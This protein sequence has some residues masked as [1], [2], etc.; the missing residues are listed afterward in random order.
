[1]ENFLDKI[2]KNIKKI[3]IITVLN[4]G[5]FETVDAMITNELII[6]PYAQIT[7]LESDK[8]IVGLDIEVPIPNESKRFFRIEADSRPDLVEFI[9]DLTKCGFGQFKSEDLT[10]EE[11]DCL[12]EHGFLVDKNAAP[13]KPLFHYFLDEIEVEND[14]EPQLL[15]NLTVNPSFRFEPFDLTKVSHLIKDNNF[16]PDFPIAWVKLP[17]TEIEVG[18]WLRNEFIE[19]AQK[20]VAG[21][22][23]AFHIEENVLSKFIRAGILINADLRRKKET[24][25]KRRLEAAR[26]MFQ[27]EK[28]VV[29]EEILPSYYM[30][31]MK[32]FFREYV[33]NGFMP[34]N[35]TQARRFYEHNLPL[36][37]FFHRDFT[38][39][40]SIVVGKEVKPSYVYSASYV[41]EAALDPH[42]DRAQ[43]EYSISFQVDYQPEPEDDL[44]PWGLYVSPLELADLQYEPRFPWE[45][46]PEDDPDSRKCKKVHLKSGD[47]LFYMGRE[48]V[49]YRYS[50]PKGHTSTSLFFHYVAKDFAGGL[51]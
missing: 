31:A 1:V 35:D 39:L 22:K 36:A 41:E 12:V 38:K 20:F 51:D 18:Y 45:H 10:D 4:S 24:E 16:S 9:A 44:S 6:N 8:T 49:H 27:T 30:R 3:V 11:R 34:F 15:T 33:A 32:D 21:E 19:I 2:S 26:Q 7:I 23:L 40:M 46:Y 47:G 5:G 17:V 13:K 28:Y 43:C 29:V 37:R 42:I 50:L 14:F 25:I 48:L